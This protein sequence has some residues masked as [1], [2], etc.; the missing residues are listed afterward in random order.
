MKIK[1]QDIERFVEFVMSEELPNKLSRMRSRFVVGYAKERL[2]LV[3]QERMEIINQ[4]CKK[5]EDGELKIITDA[6][7]QH[8]EIEDLDSFNKDLSELM[9]EYFVLEA[10]EE[11]KE[12]LKCIK[13]IVLNT[14]K[15]FKGNEAL[16]YDK[17][18]DIVEELNV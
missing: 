12:M 6:T 1:N 4:Y 14:P 5:D 3:Y 7:G 17:W 13:E 16:E 8:Y 18:C 2:N 15:F 10:N 11:K 9:N